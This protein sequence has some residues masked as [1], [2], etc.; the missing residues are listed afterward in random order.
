MRTTAIAIVAAGFAAAAANVAVAAAPSD[1]DYLKAARC[2][3]LAS[4]GAPATVDVAALD[5][6]L[7]SAERSRTIQV[8]DRAK[9]EE[10]RGKRDAKGKYQDRVVAELNGACMAY[11]GGASATAAAGAPASAT[12]QN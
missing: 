5:A 8:M 7:K 12:S 2:R 9:A 1:L 6:Y 3:G 10:A 4:A 11:M